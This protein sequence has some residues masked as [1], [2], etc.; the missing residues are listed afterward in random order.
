MSEAE[1]YAFFS[2]FLGLTSSLALFS[3]LSASSD[4]SNLVAAKK[5]ILEHFTRAVTQSH[6]IS[7]FLDTFPQAGKVPFEL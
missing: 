1:W 6:D 3:N 2:F 4:P 5:V 7:K